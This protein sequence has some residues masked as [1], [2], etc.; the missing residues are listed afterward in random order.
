[1]YNKEQT[2]KLQYILSIKT[3]C[4]TFTVCKREKASYVHDKE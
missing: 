4:Y 3:F 2:G 1:M